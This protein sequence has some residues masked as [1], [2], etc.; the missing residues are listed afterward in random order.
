MVEQGRTQVSIL[1]PTYNES[2]NIIGLLKSVAESLPKNI[3]A[4]TIVIDDNSP[5]GTGRLVEDYIR[6]VGKKAG[7]TIG[8]IHRR[9]KRG[10]G[11]AIIHG[12]QQARGETIVVMDSDFSHPPSAIPRMLESLWQSSCD[13]VVASRYTR[14]G[15]IHGWTL[16]RRIISKVATGI[17]KR[18]LGVKQDDPMSG[19]FAFRRNLLQGFKLDGIGYKMLLEM[20]VKARGA[21]V[22]EI[23]YTFTDRRLGDSKLGA[24]TMVDYLRSVWRLYRFGRARSRQE[25]RASVRFASKAARFYTVGAT[26]LLVNYLFS[27]MLAGWPA[28]MWYLHANLAGIAASVS[29]NFALNKHWTF[30]DRD[31]GAAR[32]VSQ[33][34]KFVLFSSAGALVQLGMVYHLVEGHA[35][36]YPVALVLAVLT[37]SFGNFILNK[38]L[39]F[40]EKIWS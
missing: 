25:P 35:L 24:G 31:F 12:I 5:D 14:G 1:V 6:S 32:T 38:K 11:S 7:Q 22:K 9:T 17:A 36:E 28:D 34:G 19:F 2:Q 26:G 18:G 3:A 13:I 20:L 40:K 37:A 16:K 4:E 33:Y 29:T 39:T 21:S 10:L 30:E 23:P 15:A 27:A 8:I